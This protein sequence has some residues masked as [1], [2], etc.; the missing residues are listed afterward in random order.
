ML[1]VTRKPLTMH[2]RAMLSAHNNFSEHNY[3]FN[4]NYTTKV[5]VTAAHNK[6]TTKKSPLTLTRKLF[7]PEKSWPCKSVKFLTVVMGLPWQT[8]MRAKTSYAAKF[9]ARVVHMIDDPRRSIKFIMPKQCDHFAKHWLARTLDLRHL[10]SRTHT[11]HNTFFFPFISSF[12]R[13]QSIALVHLTLI[14]HFGEN[15]SSSRN[16]DDTKRSISATEPIW[17]P[18][19]VLGLHLASRTLSFSQYKYTIIHKASPSQFIV[20]CRL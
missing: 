13:R 1:I 11:K 8:K 20:Y 2:L 9:I 12:G 10:Y 6:P 3:R 17:S 4:P 5:Y 16:I 7:S 18:S 19:Q 14:K 15:K